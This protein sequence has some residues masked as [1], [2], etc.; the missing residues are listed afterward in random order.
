VRGSALHLLGDTGD[1][2]RVGTVSVCPE[3]KE[4]EQAD[5]N[6]PGAGSS[7]WSHWVT[8]EGA[9]DYVT[10]TVTIRAADPLGNRTAQALELPVVFDNVAPVL[11]ADPIRTQAPLSSTQTVLNGAVSDG[12]PRDR[13]GAHAA[14]E[15]RCRAPRR[16]PRRRRGH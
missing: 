1:N 6:T 12:G 3:G 7:G 8:A 15:R 4:C 13:V 11:T 2:T 10:K 16:R 9:L 5:L 14:A